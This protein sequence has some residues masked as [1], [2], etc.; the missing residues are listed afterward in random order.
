[1]S[2]VPEIL[3]LTDMVAGVVYASNVSAVREGVTVYDVLFPDTIVVPG[4]TPNPDTDEPETSEIDEVNESTFPEMLP[5]TLDGV[6]VL[7]RVSV[8]G[9]VIEGPPE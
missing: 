4:I 5:S 9:L 8:T 1:M 2:V 7:R 6:G 3:P